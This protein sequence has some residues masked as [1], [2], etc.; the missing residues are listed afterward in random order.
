MTVYKDLIGEAEGT[1]CG[2][3][4]SRTLALVTRLGDPIAVGAFVALYFTIRKRWALPGSTDVDSD[5]IAQ[6]SLLEGIVP[7]GASLVDVTIGGDDLDVKPKLYVYDV[8]G[9][10]T[11]GEQKVLVRGNIEL[12]PKGTASNS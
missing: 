7:D 10:T 6:A 4:F 2:S 1:V 8:K 5:V 12:L 9:I 11:S 3:D